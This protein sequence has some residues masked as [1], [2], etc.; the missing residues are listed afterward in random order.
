[1]QRVRSPGEARAPRGVQDSEQTQGSQKPPGWR[2]P[3]RTTTQYRDNA[4][5]SDF[6]KGLNN[7][8]AATRKAL[9]ARGLEKASISYHFQGSVPDDA[10]IAIVAPGKTVETRFPRREVDDCHQGV[11]VSAQVEIQ[12]LVDEFEHAPLSNAV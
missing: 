6:Q 5:M 11:T 12:R 9:Y 2:R 7:I 10:Q 1:M 4:T 8:I 3:R